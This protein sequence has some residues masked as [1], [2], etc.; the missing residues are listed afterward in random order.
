M[1]AFRVLFALLLCTLLIVWLSTGIRSGVI[2]DSIHGVGYRA[3]SVLPQGSDL[4]SQ[5]KRDQA[6]RLEPVVQ[7]SSGQRVPASV[8]QR[9]REQGVQSAKV[10]RSFTAPLIVFSCII[11]SL[12]VAIKL[13]MVSGRGMDQWQTR[14]SRAFV[15]VMV[16]GVFI[17]AA[18]TFS[19]VFW[20]GVD[21][22]F[23]ARSTQINPN[24]SSVHVVGNTTL[25][26]NDDTL[27][28]LY[29][30][31]VVTAFPFMVLVATRSMG[32]WA[33]IRVRLADSRLS[34]IAQRTLSHP[35]LQ[36]RFSM[37]STMGV[38]V[39]CYVLLALVLWSAPWSTTIAQS[40]WTP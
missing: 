12:L 18:F 25:S 11:G 10:L 34:A 14:V 35:L 1:N 16:I 21:D 36:A 7:Q 32:D 19:R 22:A 24:S 9:Q 26:M 27:V 30:A 4:G 37:Q 29:L 8:R 6:V 13:N 38:I 20:T 40:I 23:I 15:M 33:S 2:Y 31:I 3:G 28:M 39:A 17:S 5:L